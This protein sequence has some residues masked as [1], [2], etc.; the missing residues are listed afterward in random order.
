MTKLQAVHAEL[1][2]LRA[3]Y[4]DLVDPDRA[5]AEKMGEVVDALVDEV[6]TIEAQLEGIDDTLQRIDD[7]LQHASESD[8]D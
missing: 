3:R 7:T 8:D 5:I 4:H 6:S 1:V 2:A